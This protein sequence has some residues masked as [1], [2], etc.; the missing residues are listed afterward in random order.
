MDGN[1]RRLEVGRPQWVSNRWP[2]AR[3]FVKT[4][5][6][7]PTHNPKER[8]ALRKMTGRKNNRF[9][10][11]APVPRS[12]RTPPDP[13]E[14]DKANRCRRMTPPEPKWCGGGVVV[15]GRCAASRV[16]FNLGPGGTPAAPVPIAKIWT[17]W[18][19]NTPQQ[20]PGFFPQLMWD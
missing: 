6:T 2:E 10:C 7:K 18:V 19:L 16:A 1:R 8:P 5:T 14:V 9:C 3:M 4:R 11:A 20:D 12:I 17:P 15:H 13:S